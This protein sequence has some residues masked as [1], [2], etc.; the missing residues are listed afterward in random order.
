MELYLSIYV[1][2]FRLAGDT[3]NISNEWPLF[4]KPLDFD[5]S[6]SLDGSVYLGVRQRNVPPPVEYVRSKYDF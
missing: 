5:A 3:G 2:D 1:D 6:T 4:N